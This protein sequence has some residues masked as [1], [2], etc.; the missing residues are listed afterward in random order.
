M[1]QDG[2]ESALGLLLKRNQRRQTK[3][4]N[5][6]I[7]PNSTHD[8]TPFN[9]SSAEG[10]IDQI[11]HRRFFHAAK[12]GVFVD[13]GAGRPGFLSI[14]RLYR[15]LGWRVLAVE[16]NPFFCDEYRQA[17]LSVLQYACSDHD[18]DGQDFSVVN[19]HNT[20]Y[21]GGHVTF[22]SFSSIA[23]KENYRALL[24]VLDTTTIKVNI[25][26][27]DT[28]L[29][30]HAPEVVQID[31]L[32][33]DVEGW[34]IEVLRGLSIARYRPAVI[35]LEN[36]FEGPEY[37]EYM[38]GQGYCFWRRR[39]PNDIFVPDEAVGWI[40]R[41]LLNVVHLPSRLRG[42]RRRLRGDREK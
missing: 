16:P 6:D 26:K 7:S 37:Q 5:V 13:V 39:Y 10:H 40:E 22:E 8:S 38:K 23:V 42:A 12:S 27:L 35:I 18:A 2:A 1:V 28:I 30:E 19:S 3:N 32:S 33:I 29:A 41:M 34:E 9:V 20:S 21:G 24:P 4:P 25:R 31:I 15:N 11:I 17:G 36:L 14:S